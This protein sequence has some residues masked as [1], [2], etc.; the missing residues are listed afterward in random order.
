[1]GLETVEI[2]HQPEAIVLVQDRIPLLSVL[3]PTALLQEL[4]TVQHHNLEQVLDLNR[5]HHALT[6]LARVMAAEDPQEVV[7]LEAEDHQEAAEDNNNTPMLL[8]KSH[9][10][11]MSIINLL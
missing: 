8:L 2:L 3:M 5:R 6:P 10:F 7:A 4:T 1:M 9:R 11:F